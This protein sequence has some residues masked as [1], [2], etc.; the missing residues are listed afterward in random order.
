[1][2]PRNIFFWIEL[3]YTNFENSFV[4]A[5]YQYIQWPIHSKYGCFKII[6]KP[7]NYFYT[8]WK[9]FKNGVFSG[10]YFPVLGLNP[11]RYSASLRIQSECWKIRTRKKLHKVTIKNA[12]FF[13]LVVISE[14]I[15]H[16]TTNGK[17]FNTM[18][19]HDFNMTSFSPCCHNWL[20]CICFC[21][22]I[23]LL[24]RIFCL[25]CYR[26]CVEQ[27]LAFHWDIADIV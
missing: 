17:V 9:V 3:L 12:N 25:A 6:K 1:M 11:E 26:L 27:W 2:I 23:C 19:S 24:S 4:L 13:V 21:A 14:K 16:W 5:I 20:A 15:L 8:A 10:P 18:V 22:C 7:F